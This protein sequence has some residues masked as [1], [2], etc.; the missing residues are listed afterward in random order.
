M[1]LYL[2]VNRC[3]LVYQRLSL[4]HKKFWH[5]SSKFLWVKIKS[6]VLF[7]FPLYMYTP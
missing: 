6:A 7:F 4:P 5:Y 2:V 1:R 3:Q